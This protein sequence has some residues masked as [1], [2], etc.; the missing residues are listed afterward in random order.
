MTECGPG[1]DTDCPF[2]GLRRTSHG[3]RETPGLLGTGPLCEEARG[4]RVGFA[5]FD[6]RRP[7]L[8]AGGELWA[9]LL[10]GRAWQ[11]RRAEAAGGADVRGRAGVEAPLCGA[12]PGE[13]LRV[14]SGCP[15]KQ[16][17]K[18]VK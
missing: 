16:S 13:S 18:A 7:L 15:G 1:L 4:S 11:G 5:G 9:W 14:D 10:S 6:R 3:A 12:G 2:R 17:V 8:G